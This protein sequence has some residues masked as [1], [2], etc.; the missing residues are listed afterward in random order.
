M[1]QIFTVQLRTID[2]GAARA[3]YAAVLGAQDVVVLPLPEQALARG[4]RPHWLGYI[5]IPDLDSGLAAALARGATQLGP[6]WRTPDDLPAV[7]I[8]DPGGAVVALAES[9][10]ARSS[11]GPPVLW[12]QLNTAEVARTQDFYRAL[13]GWRCDEAARAPSAGVINHPFA[14]S[15]EATPVGAMADIAGRTDVHPHWLYQFAVPSLENA[16]ERVRGLGGLALPPLELASGARVG[17]CDDPQG[18]AFALVER[19][20]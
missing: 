17:V 3:F 7:V 12:Y 6:R 8:R 20:A 11:S 5:D 19:I 14:W 13:F 4:A 18:A 1:A 2:L 16:L 9:A 15:S 10:T